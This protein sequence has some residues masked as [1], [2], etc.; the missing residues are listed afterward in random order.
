MYMHQKDTHVA[1]EQCINSS[2]ITKYFILY[3]NRYSFQYI[4][5]RNH[6]TMTETSYLIV[7]LWR[8]GNWH[9]FINEGKSKKLER[10]GSMQIIRIG[11]LNIEQ[12]LVYHLF[13]IYPT[14]SESPSLHLFSLSWKHHAYSRKH[15]KILPL[16]A[17]ISRGYWLIRY[18]LGWLRV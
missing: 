7:L 16:G 1:Y 11:Q 9:L 18:V 12:T 6:F 8:V 14:A 4:T 17:L 10:Y 13:W 15:D 5:N 2:N 3:I